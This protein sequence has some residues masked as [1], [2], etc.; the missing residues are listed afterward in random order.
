MA[1]RPVSN[2]EI[3]ALPSLPSLDVDRFNWQR[4]LSVAL[5]AAFLVTILW[6]LSDFGFT[7]AFRTLPS[8]PLF[9]CAFAGYY[10][11]LPASEWLIFRR[12]WKLPVAGFAALL[13]KLVSNEVLLGYSGEAYFY[14]WARQNARLVTAPFGAI[15]DVSI[16][17]ALAGNIATLVMLIVAWPLVGKVAPQFHGQAVLL[18]AGVMI[19]MSMAVLL[20][21]GKLFSLGAPELRSIFAVHIGR[22][23][24]TTLLSG[25]MWHAAL[26][27]EP[28]VWLIILATLQLLVTRLPLV[29][30]KD[31]VF[32]SLA[33]F[34]IGNDGPVGELIA[35]I[36]AV[37][38]ATHLL[39]GAAL[40]IRDAVAATSG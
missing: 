16:L 35:M 23:I 36:A 19:A 32:A 30:N 10:L 26:P 34:L 1:T 12:L 13:R 9:W 24:V 25:V 22:L 17:S 8:R 37:I 39:I 7:N 40:L 5:S 4:W 27:Q 20:F 2:S 15:K 33:I 6:K 3:L 31:M 11:A 28:L 14:T 38:L 18:S 21:R 29:P